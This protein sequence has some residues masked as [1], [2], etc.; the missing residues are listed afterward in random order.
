MLALAII[1]YFG[2]IKSYSRVDG[3]DSE[4][5]LPNKKPLRPHRRGL[6]FWE[7]IISSVPVAFPRHSRGGKSLYWA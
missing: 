5:I 3:S 4:G 2:W 7:T 6:T 1:G